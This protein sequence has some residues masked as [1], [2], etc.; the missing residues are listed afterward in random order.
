MNL[1]P[2]IIQQTFKVAISMPLLLECLTNL[3]TIPI[4]QWRYIQMASSNFHQSI[5]TATLAPRL[6]AF[7]T[8]CCASL[9]HPLKA[10]KR[11]SPFT[12]SRFEM[13]QYTNTKWVHI[14]HWY[15][16]SSLPS[17]TAHK[18]CSDLLQCG[19]PYQQLTTKSERF[20]HLWYLHYPAFIP[21]FPK[22]PWVPSHVRYT[23]IFVLS[24]QEDFWRAKRVAPCVAN[25]L[26]QIPFWITLN[27][28][29]LTWQWNI[30]MFNTK[31]IFNGSSFHCYISLPECNCYKTTIWTDRCLTALP[32]LSV[33]FS[34]SW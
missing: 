3:R 22:V 11:D 23:V 15:V 18:V 24:L 1:A 12:I 19:M 13:S 17:D 34:T 21:T 5:L 6:K 20:G 10:I 31:Y 33:R 25:N 28:S 16:F 30:A 32:S 2:L 8:G 14:A 29:K 7:V 9:R 26:W 4:D 27:W